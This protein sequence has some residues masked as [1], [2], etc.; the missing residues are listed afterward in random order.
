MEIGLYAE[1]T[2]LSSFDAVLDAM[3]RLGLTRIEAGTG[4]QADRPFLDVD[5]LLAS[6]TARRDLLAKLE[7]HGLRFSALNAS[8]FTMHPRVGAEH[9]ELVRKTMRLA[10]LLGLDRIIVQSGV[11]G[12]APDSRIPNWV[13]YPWPPDTADET[14]R[15]WEAA[16][17]LWTELAATG[18]REGVT[19]LCFEMHPLNL[20]HNPPT[21]LHLRE[22]VGPE[23]GANFDPSHLMWVGCDIPACIRLLAG[24]I[25]HVHI[26][27]VRMMPH[28]IATVG[29]IDSRPWVGFRDRPWTFCTPGFGHDAIWWRQFFEALDDAGYDDVASIENEDPYLP[30]MAGVE[31]TVSFL[32]G[33]IQG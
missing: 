27:D 14:R 15:Q 21:L 25:Y 4:G 30:G 3:S 16:I 24:A 13:T 2:G 33:I 22:A 7:G 1:S 19:R 31:Q 12:D 5:A 17:E 8:A 26:K 29:V 20:V 11:P 28:N 18:R 10:G 6:E 32:R 23:I 9:A